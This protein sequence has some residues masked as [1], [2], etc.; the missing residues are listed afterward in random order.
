[1]KTVQRNKIKFKI[2][3]ECE[4]KEK[5]NMAE[6][7]IKLVLTYQDTFPELMQEDV[8]GFI[9]DARELHKQLNSK[10]HFTDWIKPYIKENNLYKFIQ[11]SDFTSIHA[12]VNPTNNIPIINYKL[13][14]DMSKELCLLSKS[15]NGILVR[16]YFILMEKTLRKYDKWENTRNPE[17]KNA[18]KMKQEILNWCDRLGYDKTLEI[19]QTREF[20]MLNQNLIGLK[21]SEIKSYMGYKDKVTRDH[22]LEKQNR[23]IDILQQLNISLLLSNMSFEDRNNIIK[24]TCDIQYPELKINSK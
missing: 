7:D 2:F 15:D 13:T 14:L 4:L 3:E 11:E 17:K 10:R 24:T 1:M 21:A 6:D 23:V 5:L 19:F 8:D 16:K 9:I 22:L 18:I 12:G 20:N